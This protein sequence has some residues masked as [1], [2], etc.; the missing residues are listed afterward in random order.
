MKIYLK[1]S[2]KQ[3]M[4]FALALTFLAPLTHSATVSFINPASVVGPGV[5]VTSQT[6]SSVAFEWDAISGASGYVVWYQR[7]DNY[8]SGNFETSTPNISFSGLQPGNYTFHFKVIINGSSS[9]FTGE[10]LVMG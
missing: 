6:G 4:L 5:R 3:A 2:W 9:E 8:T 10:D 7:N 1:N